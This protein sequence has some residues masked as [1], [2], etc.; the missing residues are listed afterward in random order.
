MSKMSD[1][2]LHMRPREKLQARGAAA[3]SDFGLPSYL[4]SFE[5]MLSNLL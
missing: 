1:R 2:P 5:E 4:T 3:L